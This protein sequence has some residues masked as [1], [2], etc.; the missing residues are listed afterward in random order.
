MPDD[1]IQIPDTIEVQGPTA[2]PRCRA[3]GAYCEVSGVIYSEPGDPERGEIARR[4]SVLTVEAHGCFA[5]QRAAE[6]INLDT[7]PTLL[8]QLTDSRAAHEA[9]IEKLVVNRL[10]DRGFEGFDTY[11]GAPA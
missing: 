4:T 7:V 2:Y 11:R 1:A 9:A 8:G 3:C 6:T 5:G 10:R